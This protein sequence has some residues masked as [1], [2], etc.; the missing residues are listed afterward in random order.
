LNKEITKQKREIQLKDAEITGKNEDLKKAAKKER[1]LTNLIVSCSV[2]IDYALELMQN[3]NNN[4]NCDVKQIQQKV[5]KTLAFLQDRLKEELGYKVKL[6]S[7]DPFLQAGKPHEESENVVVTESANVPNGIEVGVN[8]TDDL[9][10]K[11]N[12]KP[13]YTVDRYIMTEPVLRK[14]AKTQVKKECVNVEIQ[15]NKILPIYSVYRSPDGS[16]SFA[17]STFNLYENSHQNQ[18]DTKNSPQN[19]QETSFPKILEPAKLSQT[20][21]SSNKNITEITLTKTQTSGNL[22]ILVFC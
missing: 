16:S 22:K 8:T 9:L 1:D 17:K 5:I 20:T 19:T 12:V 15:T 4:G 7:T 3:A 11:Y 10:R 13:F 6:F 21:Y 18:F 2:K 14:D